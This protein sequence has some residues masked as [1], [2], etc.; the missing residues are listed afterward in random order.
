MF[1]QVKLEVLVRLGLL[2][3][4]HLKSHTLPTPPCLFF[5]IFSWKILSLR[6]SRM[7]ICFPSLL[8]GIKLWT[9]SIEDRLLWFWILCDRILTN[10]NSFHKVPPTFYFLLKF[11]MENGD[12]LC[13]KKGWSMPKKKE[14]VPKSWAPLILSNLDISCLGIWPRQ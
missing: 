11:L 8:H 14:G 4:C 1:N 2:S 9:K 10:Q 5:R 12:I 7:P 13:D 6:S 3:L